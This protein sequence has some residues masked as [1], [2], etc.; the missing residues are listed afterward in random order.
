MAILAVDGMSHVS[1]SP[2][3]FFD[4]LEAEDDEV[5]VVSLLLDREE[6]GTTVLRHG[7]ALIA[8]E[9]CGRVAWGVWSAEETHKLMALCPE[10]APASFIHDAGHWIAAR[11]VL[12]LDRGREWLARLTDAEAT[13]ACIHW[14]ASDGLPAFQARVQKPDA[15]IRVL[16]GT[17]TSAGCYLASAKRPALGTIWRSDDRPELLVP[18]MVEYEGVTYAPLTL[19]LLGLLVPTEG[20]PNA[21]PPPFGLFVGRLE[22]RAWLSDLA[23]DGPAFE[24]LHVYIGWD[25]ER[26]DLSDLVLDL[27]QFVGDELV[28]QLRAPLEDTIINDEV[29]TAGACITSLPTIGRGVA[30]R[31]SLTTRDG[32]LLD[33]IGP[34][35]L[36]ESVNIGLVVNGQEQPPIVIGSNAPAPGLEERAERQRQV[37]E[38]AGELADQ[39]AEGRLLVDRAAAEERL[40]L[41]VSRAR[42]ELLVHDR[43][44]GQDPDDWRLLDDVPVPVRVVTAKIAADIPDIGDHVRARYRSK[45]P[46]HERFWIW[47]G[48]GLSLGGSPTTFG[49]S[50]VRIGRLSAADSDLLRSVFEGLWESDLFHDVPRQS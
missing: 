13:G 43:Y 45:A 46:M 48:G 29:R 4:A 37:E 36:V 27:E 44:F 2:G 18:I 30:S 3:A 32:A 25:P 12:S 14:P 33:R 23:G 7:S 24:A 34:H 40:R 21:G 42:E 5:L 16:P 26:I 31:V 10:T 41:A 49:H 28:N 8:P 19:C 50:P 17:D 9:A 38:Q 47:R 11:A 15:L 39:G 20:V 6:D 35:H 22:R 1:G